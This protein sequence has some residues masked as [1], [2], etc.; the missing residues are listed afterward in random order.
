M[1]L[2]SV[3]YPDIT[4]CVGSPKSGIHTTSAKEEFSNGPRDI[5]SGGIYFHE[6]SNG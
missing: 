1:H 5:L 3:K 4:A 2:D 6:L